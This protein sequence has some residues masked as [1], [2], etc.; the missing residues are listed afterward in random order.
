MIRMERLIL[1]M[2]GLKVEMVNMECR[3][4]N[5]LADILAAV[6]EELL[7]VGSVHPHPRR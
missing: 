6:R 3:G 5:G 4:V 1:E 2:E 7:E